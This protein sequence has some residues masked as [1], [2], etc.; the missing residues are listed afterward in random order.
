MKLLWFA[1]GFLAC[2]GAPP[3]APLTGDR[4]IAMNTPLAELDDVAPSYGK[5]ELDRALATERLALVTQEHAAGEAEAKDDSGEALRVALADLSVH[6]RFVAT[7]EA[8]A[9]TGRWCPPRLD[10][11]PWSYDI[12][13]DAAK[14]PLDNVLRF[15]RDDWRKIASELFGRACACR[16]IACVDSLGVAIDHLETRPMPDVR[17]DDDAAAA[18]THAR[19]CLYRLRGLTALPRT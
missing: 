18:I 9:A 11:P 13:D 17:D 1:W 12:A 6:R 16:T 14:P 10:D 5:P 19:E 8:C 15:D 2:G 7:L 4:G 3:H